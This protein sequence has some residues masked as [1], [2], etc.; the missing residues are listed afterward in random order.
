M[1]DYIYMMESRLTP[2]QQKAVV[3][4]QEVSRAQEFNL[5]LTGGAVRD[6]IS[7]FPIRDLD[8]TVQGNALRLQK[9]LEKGGAAIHGVDEDLKSLLVQFPG[10]V[11]AE[12]SMARAEKYGEKAG[13]PPEIEPGTIIDDLRRR[14]F[15]INAMALSL[16]E[17]SRGLL[18]DPANGLA[19]IEAKL[20]RILHNYAFVEEPSRLIRATR[21]ASRFH[22]TLEE[23]TQARYDAGRENDYIQYISDRAIGYEIGQVAYEEDPL[24]IMKALE[25]EGWLKVL[26]PHWTVSKVDSS[27]LASLLK[28]RRQM[29]DLGYNLDAAPAAMY[30]LT[31]RLGSHDVADMQRRIPRKG[32]VEAWRRLED[33]AKE[34]AQRLVSKEA[35]T[36]SRTWKLLSNSRPEA[37]LF[38]SVTARP[39]KVVQKLRNFFG[40]WRQL[41]SKIPLPEMVELRITPDL[42]IYPQLERAIFELLLD[43]KMRSHSQA[44]KFL[45][46]FAPPPPPPPP[47][48][49][50]KRGRA[51]KAE[52]APP[53]K[54]EAGKKKGEKAAAEAPA[55]KAA[56]PAKKTAPPA[57]AAPKK[58]APAK[59]AHKPAKARP[60]KKKPAKKRR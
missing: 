46:P 4:V 34:L 53:A 31:R 5:Y 11:R 9:D 3:Q 22:W 56:E 55:A 15:T 36:P 43:G 1:A 44:M 13:K 23:R 7:G 30:F 27:G 21:F 20:I 6:M 25:K 59:P 14:D 33:E 2:E 50:V 41:K 16:N 19:D 17:G 24:H 58:A 52:P 45:K 26:N 38:L 57:K 35:A 51:A 29:V 10:N 40:K 42:P 47:P 60:A 39:Q 37:I 32:F 48:P 54:P 18:L 28:V 8:F 12:I 49:P